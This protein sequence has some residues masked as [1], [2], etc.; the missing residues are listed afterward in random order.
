MTFHCP[1]KASH[2]CVFRDIFFLEARMR[3]S[4]EARVVAAWMAGAS[5]LEPYW[6]WFSSWNPVVASLRSGLTLMWQA[7]GPRRCPLLWR[8]HFFAGHIWDPARVILSDFA[9]TDFLPTTTARYVRRKRT[10]S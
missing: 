10:S 8:S 3:Y 5:K 4:E 9:V 6:A 2:P 1:V 7:L